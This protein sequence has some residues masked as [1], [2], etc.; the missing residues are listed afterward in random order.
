MIDS[1]QTDLSV[2]AFL[3]LRNRFFD[4]G[5]VPEIYSLRDKRNVQDDPLDEY[6]CKVL[7]ADLRDGVDVARASGPLITP[8]MA[9]FRPVLC[10]QAPREELRADSTRIFGLEVKKLERKGS[11]VPRSSGMD[12][13]TTP[14][15]GTVRVYDNTQNTLDI[16]GFYLFV[17][18]EKLSNVENTYRLTALALC[19]GDLLNDDFDFYLSIVGQRTKEI[20]LGTY[21][22]GANRLRPM[23]VFSNPLG[24]PFLDN[25]ST[26][27]HARGDLHDDYPTLRR[28]GV[29]ERSIPCKAK[30]ESQ[31]ADLETRIF[32]C[33]RDCRDAEAIDLFRARDPFPTPKSTKTTAPRGRFV[34]PVQPCR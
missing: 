32:H 16:K 29:I 26:L 34:I 12:Y 23:L 9:I 20:G 4:A 28:V 5:A 27:I 21:G 33:Y 2:E 8:D 24:V 30:E 11:L 25:Q 14:P 13:N 15:C 22:D 17:C 19:D 31:I 10:D 3:A 6:I 7:E 18:Q 1:M